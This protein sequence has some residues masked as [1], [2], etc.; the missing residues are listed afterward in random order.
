[1]DDL[2]TGVQTCALPIYGA[3]ATVHAVARQISDPGT[4]PL[5]LD[6]PTRPLRREILWRRRRHVVHGVTAVNVGNVKRESIGGQRL[7]EE[8]IGRASCRE[9]V[10]NRGG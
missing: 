4:G 8:Q 6:S 9:R 1:R 5:Q 7:H 10:R 2:V 3:A